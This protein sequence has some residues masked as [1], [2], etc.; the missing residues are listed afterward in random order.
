MTR[1]LTVHLLDTDG[2]LVK[3]VTGWVEGTASWTHPARGAGRGTITLPFGHADLAAFTPRRFVRFTLTD[4]AGANPTAVFTWMLQR[5]AV[6]RLS[7]DEGGGQV[8]VWTGDG[9]L[10]ALGL[11]QF[12]SAV[13]VGGDNGLRTIG[14][15]QREWDDTGVPE[16]S[17]R[18]YVRSGLRENWHIYGVMRDTSEYAYSPALGYAAAFMSLNTFLFCMLIAFIFY[19]ASLGDK[20]KGG[21][22]TDKRYMPEQPVPAMAG[23]SPALDE[24]KC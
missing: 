19:V 11:G 3:E 18:G 16:P 10:S 4:I 5:D 1:A 2:T 6:D 7:L 9:V 8:T 20:G 13:V 23:A 22:P 24:K 15:T 21:E 17:D 14:W 12:H